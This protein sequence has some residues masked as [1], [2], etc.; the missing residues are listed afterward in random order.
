MKRSEMCEIINQYMTGPRHNAT[1]STLLK[2]LEDAG[3]VPPEVMAPG[4][5]LH[6]APFLQHVWEPED[7]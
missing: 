3:M 5:M 4:H 1:A 2:V 6:P 7:E